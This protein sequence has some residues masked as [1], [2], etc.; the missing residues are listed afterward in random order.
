[1][2]RDGALNLTD[3]MDCLRQYGVDAIVDASHPFAAELHHTAYAAAQNAKIPYLRFDR[4]QNLFQETWIHRVNSHEEAA[5]KA[6]EL[7]D[8]LFLTTGSRHVHLYAQSAQEYHKNITVRVM[9]ASDSLLACE[10][11]GLKP[12]QIIAETGPFSTED[13]LHLL[14][15]YKCDV[16][17]SKDSGDSGG[18]PEKIAAAE[19]QNIPVVLVNRP[20]TQG[21]L[22]GDLDGL[23]KE[24]Q[25]L[26]S[27]S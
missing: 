6:S 22:F 23:L 9:P 1:M 25:R 15:K 16:L 21:K 12:R 19:L 17:I 18:L 7:G 11:A 20:A 2:Q 10:N 13:N 26:L 3:F 8:H 27:I 24:L 4:P 14:R 5:Q